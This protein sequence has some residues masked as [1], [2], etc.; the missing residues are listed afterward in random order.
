MTLQSYIAKAQADVDSLAPDAIAAAS[1][2]ARSN[3]WDGSTIG[4]PM[5]AGAHLYRL[6]ASLARPVARGDLDLSA[7]HAS[8][9]NNTIAAER[10]GELGPYK[11]ADVVGGMRDALRLHLE[12]AETRRELT[13]Q[14]I[15]RLLAP[16]IDQRKPRNMLLAEAH[17][18][19]GA[20][21]FPFSEQEVTDLV[22]AE[23]YYSLP[24]RGR[25]YVR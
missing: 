7:A 12:R 24:A 13:A 23:V 3:G 1:E 10:R 20:A 2:L 9:I 17:G 6:A 11:A 18:V 8:L 22:T 21:D 4:E 19:N 16:M 14:R 5:P 25:S 15:R